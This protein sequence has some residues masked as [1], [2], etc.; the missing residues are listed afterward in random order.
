MEEVKSNQILGMLFVQ[1]KLLKK[2]SKCS[3]VVGRDGLCYE[4]ILLLGCVNIHA[5][6]DRL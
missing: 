2:S 3:V 1:F 5:E 6:I 4:D